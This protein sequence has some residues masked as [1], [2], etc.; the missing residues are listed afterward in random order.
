[1]RNHYQLEREGFSEAAA[2][3]VGAALFFIYYLY[4]LDG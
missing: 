2:A 1:M 3:G 4:I